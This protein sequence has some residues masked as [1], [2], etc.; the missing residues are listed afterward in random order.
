[1]Q[2]GDEMVVAGKGG[3]KDAAQ[4]NTEYRERSICLGRRSRIVII[5]TAF[6]GREILVAGR[7]EVVEAAINAEDYSKHLR[8]FRWFFR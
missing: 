4:N 6:T 8:S 1:M 2:F 3:R 5:Q 7:I